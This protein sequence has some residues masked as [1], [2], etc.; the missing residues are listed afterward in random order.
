MDGLGWVVCFRSLVFGI[1]WKGHDLM[2]FMWDALWI[3]EV[4]MSVMMNEAFWMKLAADIL[5]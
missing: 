2:E 5:S 1:E 4:V 3:Y